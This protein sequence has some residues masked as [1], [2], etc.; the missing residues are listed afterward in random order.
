[1]T[2]SSDT[3]VARSTPRGY[4]GIGVIR[5]SGPDAISLIRS[6]FR[7][8]GADDRF[9][10]RRALYG[11]VHDP[12]TGNVIDDGIAVVMRGPA[13]YT[14]E[15]VVELSLHGSPVILDM[16]ER[17]LVALGA[18][19]ATRGEFTRRAFLSGR[20]DLLQAEAV[21]D[22]IEATGPR[23]VEA[24]RSGLDRSLSGEICRIGEALKDLLA[25]VEA[26][27][28]FDDDDLEPRPDPVP[29][30]ASLVK[31]MDD[32]VSNAEKGRM[33][34]EGIRAVIVGKPN[35]G[36]STLFNALLRTERAI[37]TPHPGTTRDSL[38]ERIMVGG[39][40]FILSD[41]AGVRQYPEPIE[42]EGI[43]RTKAIAGSADIVVVVLDA[44]SHL[45]QEDLDVLA[46]A[47]DTRTILV[48]NKTDLGDV[49][50][51]ED[52]PLGPLALPRV[53]LSA[54]T[55]EGL[56]GLERQLCNVA[57]ELTADPAAEPSASLTRR[58]AMLME[59]AKLPLVSLMEKFG[60]HD[61][62]ELEIVSLEL[63]RALEPLEEITGERVDEGILDRIFERFCVG[64]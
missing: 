36:K 35:V 39:H 17:M 1:M 45:N 29:V 7:P 11:V 62:V 51:G 6:V 28:D 49:L 9:T 56:S 44:S 34:R 64:K 20:M 14:G 2:P 53:R 23:A 16:V 13:S 48:L 42:E 38:D 10:D 41:T 55:G 26:H 60:L 52:E 46:L 5:L 59:S 50:S 21:I 24:A 27:L 58:G 19:P 8:S 37:V 30:L 33:Q 63:R 47:A 32:L 57:D 12:A 3:I 22:L 15:D 31:S 54:K 43:R 61:L 25:E 4:S 40:V 18:R